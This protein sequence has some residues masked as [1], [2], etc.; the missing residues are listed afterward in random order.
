MVCFS[1]RKSD[2]AWRIWEVKE[3]LL[4]SFAD[5]ILIIFLHRNLCFWLKATCAWEN[6]KKHVYPKIHL[7]FSAAF[8]FT[9]HIFNWRHHLCLYSG[10]PR[11]KSF[12]NRFCAQNSWRR[13]ESHRRSLF[14]FKLSHKTKSRSCTERD[15]SFLAGF[16]PNALTQRN[17]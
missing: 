10:F 12:E 16:R 2:K 1:K 15:Y 17:Q 6:E 9:K 11:C 7:T 3:N 4:K 14:W 8:P 13:V 5:Q